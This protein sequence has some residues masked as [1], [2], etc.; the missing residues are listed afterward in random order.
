MHFL[1]QFSRLIFLGVRKIQDFL[2]AR[3]NEQKS[4]IKQQQQEKHA[5][6]MHVYCLNFFEF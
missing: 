6:K 2:Y 5:I 3:L 4:E 1:S